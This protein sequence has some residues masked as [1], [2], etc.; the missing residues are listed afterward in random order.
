MEY[1]TQERMD[2]AVSRDMEVDPDAAAAQSG[3]EEAYS[4]GT[5]GYA[6]GY[7]PGETPT[8]PLAAV[9][10]EESSE[11]ALTSPPF[12]SPGSPTDWN[13]YPPFQRWSWFGKY[14]TYPTSTVGKLFFTIPGQ[15]N[16]V[17]SASVIGTHVIA[18]AGH[19]VSD[20]GILGTNF[21]FCPSYNRVAGVN[22]VRGCWGWRK[23][24]V[25]GQWFASGNFD[26]DY[27]CIILNR[28]NSTTGRSVG[29][30]TGVL[31]RAWNWPTKQMT[32]VHGYPAGSPFAGN[33]IH[34]CASTEWYE[35]PRSAMV[36]WPSILAVILPAAAVAV[37]GG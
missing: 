34:T 13:N 28:T 15:G 17:C 1:W 19:C 8:D 30:Q 24:W 7:R 6:P 4:G 5:P 33:G 20:P 12:N 21:L 22:P 2:S 25:T 27:A 18:T 35:T 36:R 14:L 31:G 10:V 3:G 9:E 26:R 16:F 23:F 11:E 32:I 29:S 37:R